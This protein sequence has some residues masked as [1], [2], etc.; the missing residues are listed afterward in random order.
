[1]KHFKYLKYI[2][3]HKWFVMV[4]CFK[5]GLYW[6]GIIH[7]WSKFMPIEFIAYA[8]HFY[9]KPTSNRQYKIGYY[10]PVD[11]GDDAFEI[12]CFHHQKLNKHHWQYWVQPI[13]KGSVKVYEMPYRYALEMVCD[14]LG[15]SKAQQT[16][17]MSYWYAENKDKLVLG[18]KT[19][20]FIERQVKCH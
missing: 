5:V 16:K 19:R 3:T 8:N 7:D 18:E 20:A 11:T 1:M 9:S 12:A 15:A 13:D 14:W 4:E 6:Q 17:G 10:K 2:L